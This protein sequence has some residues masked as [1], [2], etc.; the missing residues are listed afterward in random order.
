[1]PTYEFQCNE[2]GLVNEHVCKIDDKP[3]Y[4]P[5]R[6]GCGTAHHI[7]SLLSTQTSRPTW[8]NDEFYRTV[9]RDG[10]KPIET[11]QELSQY[12]EKNGIVCSG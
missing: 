6:C 9:Q 11:R 3:D 2:C 7:L 5:C 4:I 1:M 8:L 12:C 10:E